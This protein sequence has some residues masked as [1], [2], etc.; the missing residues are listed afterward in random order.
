MG[1]NRPIKPARKKGGARMRQLDSRRVEVWL[2]E[3]EYAT[4]EA[5]A[6]LLY[7]KVAKF[8]REAALAEAHKVNLR[9]MDRRAAS[10]QHKTA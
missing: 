10:E 3:D 6:S 8:V 9:Y 1:K 7:Q 5:S 4:V 2:S